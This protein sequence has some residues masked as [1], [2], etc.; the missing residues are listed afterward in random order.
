MQREIIGALHSFSQE[1]AYYIEFC[2]VKECNYL[3]TKCILL[4]SIQSLVC[5][6]DRKFLENSESQFSL[7][8]MDNTEKRILNSS[9]YSKKI[10]H[11]WT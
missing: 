6:D 11:E 2:K 8:V 9:P 7:H 1:E 4:V 10:L 3:F 5:F